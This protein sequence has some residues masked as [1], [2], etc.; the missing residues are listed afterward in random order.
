MAFRGDLLFEKGRRVL[1]VCHDL[2]EKLRGQYVYCD[3]WAYDY[4]WLGKLFDAVDLVPIFQLKD[5]RD[6]LGE[7]EQT[8]WQRH[9]HRCG[10]APPTAPP[11]GQQ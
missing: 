10:V 2:N 4:V 5:I 11:S 8:L 9:P 1:D 7:C 3:A 6:L